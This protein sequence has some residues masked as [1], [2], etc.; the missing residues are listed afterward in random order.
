MFYYQPL[1]YPIPCNYKLP[2]KNDQRECDLLEWI[3]MQYVVL[4]I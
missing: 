3:N 4:S 2:S 1:K